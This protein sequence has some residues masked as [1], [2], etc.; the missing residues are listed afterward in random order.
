MSIIIDSECSD[1][2][3]I[4]KSKTIDVNDEPFAIAKRAGAE[5]L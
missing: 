4:T 2:C 3:F 5:V 1:K